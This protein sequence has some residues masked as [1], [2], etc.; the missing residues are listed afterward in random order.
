MYNSV[1]RAKLNVL[2]VLCDH[3]WMNKHLIEVWRNCING[4]VFIYYISDVAGWHKGNWLYKRKVEG[5]LLINHAK[6][7][8]NQGVNIDL[9]FAIGSDDFF[10]PKLCK[11]LKPLAHKL[12]NYNVD[13]DT[14]WYRCTRSAK[15]FDLLCVAYKNNISDLSRY[16][17]TLYLPMAANCNYYRPIKSSFVYDV[18]FVGSYTPER[19]SVLAASYEVTKRIAVYGNGWDKNYKLKTYVPTSYSKTKYINDIIYYSHYLPKLINFHKLKSLRLN[20]NYSKPFSA[21]EGSILGYL[22]DNNFCHAISQ[23]KIVLGIN[24]RW[25]AIG[26]NKGYVSSRLR[27]FEVTAC[28]RFYLVQEYKDLASYFQAGVEIETWSNLD[29]L[30]SKIRYYLKHETSREKIANQGRIA[31]SQRHT[32]EIRIEKILTALN[33]LNI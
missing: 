4:K 2:L 8:I 5:E 22:P 9:I 11:K 14:Q 18:V 30:K 12:V 27:D 13:S 28:G 25:G 10:T 1:T 20:K 29:D 24:Q 21:Y 33:L 17:K 7:L 26:S 16:T 23:A 15:Y 6:S 31:T 3:F 19:E 32:W